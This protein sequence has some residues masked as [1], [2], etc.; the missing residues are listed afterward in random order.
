MTE[1]KN[2]EKPALTSRQKKY[3]KSLAHDLPALVQV[4]KEGLSESLIEAADVELE[5][6]ELIKVKL[7][8]NSGVE[9]DLGGEQLAKAT[10]SYLVQIIGKTLIL[11]RA[12]P[13]RKKDER[14]KLPKA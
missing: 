8:K 9:K 4:G 14:I 10:D 11:Y 2:D 12:N 6:R 1:I 5:R 3:L 13:K 7:G